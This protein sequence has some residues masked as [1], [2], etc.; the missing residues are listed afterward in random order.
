MGE[1]IV[2]IVIGGCLV[3]AGIAMNI[4]LTKEEKQIFTNEEKGEG[5]E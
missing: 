1:I 5:K 4:V 2:S 3:I